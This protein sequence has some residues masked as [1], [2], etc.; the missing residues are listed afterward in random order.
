MPSSLATEIR[1][2]D[3]D[4]VRASMGGI[5]WY[6]TIDLGQGLITPGVDNTAERLM[7]LQLPASLSG[8]SVLDVGAW[9][10]FFSFEAERRGAS[11]V[12]ATDSFSWRGEGWGTKAGFEL[13]RSTLNSRVEDLDIDVLDLSPDRLGVFDIVLCLGVLYHMRHPLLALERVAAVTRELL[14]VDTVVDCLSSRR[15]TMAFYPG[16]EMNNDPTNWWAPN[17][18]GCISMLRSAGF[19]HVV[20]LT[21]VRSAPYRALRALYHGIR[22]RNNVSSAYQQDRAVFHAFK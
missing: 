4:I 11:R 8:K 10:G 14:I 21:P 9:D 18:S 19:R 3:A 1:T 16:T 6:H 22:G 12:V 5:R 20:A 17:M 7:R 13:A 2:R 15:P